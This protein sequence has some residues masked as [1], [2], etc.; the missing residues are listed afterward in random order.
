MV[1]DFNTNVDSYQNKIYQ[2]IDFHT[3]ICPKCNSYGTF[4]I[5]GYY[6]RY[7][8]KLEDNTVEEIHLKICRVKCSCCNSTHAVLPS[9]VVPFSTYTIE[10]IL[11]MIKS[12][13]IKEDTQ[14]YYKDDIAYIN[15]KVLSCKNTIRRYMKIFEALCNQYTIILKEE[16]TK[17]CADKI[18][19]PFKLDVIL[20]LLILLYK[21]FLLQCV[22]FRKFNSPGM[23]IKCKLRKLFYGYILPI[24]PNEGEPHRFALIF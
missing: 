2:M 21:P 5:H 14:I 6:K 17:E 8:T 18:S 10:I 4:K 16:K 9:N 22:Y 13:I 3:T 19:H 15:K 20:N 12:L 24:P 23:Y 11:E 7:V 1:N